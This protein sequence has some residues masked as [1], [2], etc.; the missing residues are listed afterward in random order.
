MNAMVATFNDEELIAEA[1]RRIIEDA[2]K[3]PLDWNADWPKGDRP[4]EWL[5]FQ[6]LLNA[7]RSS[8]VWVIY[9]LRALRLRYQREAHEDWLRTVLYRVRKY[10][11]EARYGS[12]VPLTRMDCLRC[13]GRDLN[14]SVEAVG[15]ALIEA[16]NYR[17][18]LE[19]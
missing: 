10:E 4:V 1:E 2:E 19:N 16:D 17:L 13:V 7:K 9:E 12:G 18:G 11:T 3:R 14:M 5:S 6:L 8:I 15:A